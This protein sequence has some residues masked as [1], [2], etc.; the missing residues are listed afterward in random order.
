[1]RKT[2]LAVALTLV[3]G[4]WSASQA[5][6]GSSI[7][8]AV[9]S[10][11]VANCGF[12]TGDF[13][14]WTLSGNTTNPG[15]N[16]YGVDAFDASSGNYGAYLSEDEIAST[17][18]LVLSQVLPIQTGKNW[19]VT[20]TFWLEQDT[21]PTTGYTHTFSAS[22]GGDT[23]LSLTPTVALPGPNG[24]WTQY[25]FTV[26]DSAITSGLLSF[27]ARNDDSYWSLDDVS[28]VAPEPSSV[29]LVGT[30]LGALLL[31]RR[32]TAAE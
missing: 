26:A 23:L 25:T 15:G 6:A 29:L 27:T 5:K 22:L 2:L 7:C 21:A 31:L 18:P 4:L 13:T 14:G 12:E 16:Y 1:M 19:D 24:V 10:N 17:S 11:L 8:D 9:V 3:C 28:V 32:V 30:A 20:I